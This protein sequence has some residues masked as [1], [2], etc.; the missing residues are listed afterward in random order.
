MHSASLSS[1]ATT[2]PLVT[3]VVDEEPHSAVRTARSEHQEVSTPTQ[4]ARHEPFATED[5]SV[6]TGADCPAHGTIASVDEARFHRLVAPRTDALGIGQIW[7]DVS[8]D[9]TSSILGVSPANQLFPAS[10][11]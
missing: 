1:F 9:L 11:R 7:H 4:V 8:N 5:G 3:Y 2:A 6:L 10:T